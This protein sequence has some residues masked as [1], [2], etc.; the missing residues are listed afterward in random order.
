MP[1]KRVIVW[2]QYM[3]DRPHLTM[4]WHDPETGKRKSK[5]AETCNPLEAA[6]RLTKALGVSLDELAGLP[7]G[8]HR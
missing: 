3:G 5:S 7:E 8:G 2:L 1:E 6:A 4:Q